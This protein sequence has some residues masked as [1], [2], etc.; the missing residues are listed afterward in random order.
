MMDAL[1][2]SLIAHKGEYRAAVAICRD[3]NVPVSKHG[4]AAMVRAVS[5]L[6]AARGFYLRERRGAYTSFCVIIDQE[7]RKAVVPAE[8]FRWTDE[9]V[10]ELKRLHSTGLSMARIAVALGCKSRNAVI[11]KAHRLGLLSKQPKKAEPKKTPLKTPHGGG[12][13]DLRPDTRRASPL[14]IRRQVAPRPSPSLLAP[15]SEHAPEPIPTPIV[16]GLKLIDLG[17]FHCR[18]IVGDVA[19]SDTIYCGVP[20]TRG[21]YCACHAAIAYRPRVERP[22]KAGRA[23]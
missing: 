4:A 3:A 14:K 2:S 9:A 23:A 21:S 20:S 8:R 13:R 12:K 5:S 16:A 1:I 15:V 22:R 11:G 18:W 6:L 7:P 17:L 19:G 10:A